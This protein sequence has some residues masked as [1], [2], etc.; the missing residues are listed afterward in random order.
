[1]CYHC[2]FTGCNVMKMDNHVK[3]CQEAFRHLIGK[4]VNDIKFKKQNNDCWRVYI[5][6]DKD[7][8]VMTYCKD[9]LCPVVEH[10]SYKE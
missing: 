10:R 9:W 2:K 5:I 1:M 4:K 6:T 7:T 8:V 3:E